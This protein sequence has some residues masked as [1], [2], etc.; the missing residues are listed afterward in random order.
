MARL[1]KTIM[2]PRNANTSSRKKASTRKIDGHVYTALRMTPQTPRTEWDRVQAEYFRDGLKQMGD[3][4]VRFVAGEKEGNT[5]GWAYV[6]VYPKVSDAVFAA[7]RD[8][9]FRPHLR[10]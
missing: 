4:S 5:R 3:Y 9:M 8:H 10:R 6:Y 1:N 7:L 2:R